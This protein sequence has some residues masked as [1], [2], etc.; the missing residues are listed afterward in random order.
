MVTVIGG[1]GHILGRGNHQISPR[2]IRQVGAGNIIVAAAAD[3]LR[4]LRGRPLLVDTG[5]AGVDEALCGYVNVVVG[6]G[7]FYAYRVWR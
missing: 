6:R 3:K 2:V 1:Q 4:G 5:D 7:E